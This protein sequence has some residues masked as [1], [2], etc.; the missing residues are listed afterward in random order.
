MGASRRNAPLHF[1]P[2]LKLKPE[3]LTCSCSRAHDVCACDEERGKRASHVVNR[4]SRFGKSYSIVRTSDLSTLTSFPLP[5]SP[6]SHGILELKSTTNNP[7]HAVARTL[8]LNSNRPPRHSKAT[9]SRFPCIITP[10]AAPPPKGY[11]STLHY[12]HDQTSRDLLFAVGCDNLHL[13]SN[14]LHEAIS[15]RFF[16]PLVCRSYARRVIFHC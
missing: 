11:R 9:P 6:F 3:H 10:N 15:E 13:D 8:L 16:F 1:G 12:C 5:E 4:R 2:T 7:V 14:I